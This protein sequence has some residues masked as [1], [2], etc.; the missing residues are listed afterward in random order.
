MEDIFG[1]LNCFGET[2]TVSDILSLL[3]WGFMSYGM[4]NVPLLVKCNSR[5]LH[6]V[7]IMFCRLVY[8]E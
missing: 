1:M 6:T 2:Y 8:Y 5:L 7:T 4:Y 3:S